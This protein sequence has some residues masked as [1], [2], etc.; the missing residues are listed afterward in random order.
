[1]CGDWGL[2]LSAEE[3]RGDV[4]ADGAC[5]HDEDG[6]RREDDLEADTVAVLCVTS[7]IE[8]GARAGLPVVDHH[9]GD[10]FAEGYDVTSEGNWEE[11]HVDVIDFV[12]D[13]IVVQTQEHDGRQSNFYRKG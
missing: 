10:S 4:G 9:R 5:T 2:S 12:Q 3:E 1:M 6:G 8:V 11:V 13:S 7:F